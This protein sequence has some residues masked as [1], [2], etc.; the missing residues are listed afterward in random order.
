MSLHC[1][2]TAEGLQLLEMTFAVK[3]SSP[4]VPR[5]AEVRAW[6]GYQTS[7]SL[8]MS[9]SLLRGSAPSMAVIN[10]PGECPLVFVFPPFWLSSFSGGVSRV[11]HIVFIVALYCFFFLRKLYMNMS[12][13]HTFQ[14]MQKSP[15]HS[16]RSSI[17]PRRGHTC[18]VCCVI[19]QPPCW[20]F[21]HANYM[22]PCT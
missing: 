14:T 16:R 13:L 8:F 17:P 7:R 19:F 1:H 2:G 15:E 20:H 9:L 18:P 11:D 10:K 21:S 4:V 6:C 5:S 22:G 3:R 12:L